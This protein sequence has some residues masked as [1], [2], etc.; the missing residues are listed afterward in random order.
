[1]DAKS[2][3][4]DIDLEPKNKL[5]VFAPE[6]QKKAKALGYP[7]NDYTLYHKLSVKDYIAHESAIE[8]LQDA[9]EIVIDDER[10]LNHK[11]TTKELV[12]CCKDIKVLGKKE[13]RLLMNW[14]KLMKDQ[15]GEKENEEDSDTEK[16]DE[17]ETPKTLEQLEDLEDEEIMKDIEKLKEEKAKELR[18]KKKKANKEKT[19]L[20]QKLNLKMVHKGDEGPVEECD[21]MFT[22]KEIQTF[23]HLR[24]VTD[25]SPDILAESDEE[26]EP[27]KPKK[28]RYEK[29][30]GYLASDGLYYKDEESELEFSED[31]NESEK[32]G[33]GFSDEEEDDKKKKI[34]EKKKQQNIE[35]EDDEE[36]EE[37]KVLKSVKPLPKKAKHS[38]KDLGNISNPLIT[39]LDNRDKKS[40][41]L[42][43]AEMWFDRDI[44]K[45]L[46]T[47]QDEDAE[48]DK[49]IE[50]YKKTGGKIIGDNDVEV[51]ENNK[52]HDDDDDDDD[53]SDSDDD[54]DSDYDVNKVIAPE[55]KSKKVG[56][57]DGFE[58]VTKEQSKSF[59]FQKFLFILYIHFFSIK[60]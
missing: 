47:E 42:A 48:I 33:L 37:E 28:I 45:N 40:K 7:E 51:S 29:D 6:K 13:L 49:M 22:L 34:I 2:V 32:S 27:D 5:N 52:V 3:F 23:D 53:D 60:I 54:K 8:A 55:M 56:G 17:E 25:Q 12:E 46:E 15:F 18:R 41:K 21:D 16:K 50:V 9:S 20:A 24:Q 44:F 19:K 26:E 11:K 39:D 57:K 31:D 30:S 10:I 58:V 59:Y 35:S 14:W 4:A 38:S 36:E 43:K 1:M